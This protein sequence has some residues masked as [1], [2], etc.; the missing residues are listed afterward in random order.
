MAIGQGTLNTRNYNSNSKSSNQIEAWK[1]HWQR[2]R[3]FIV[4][5][6]LNNPSRRLFFLL[7]IAA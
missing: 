1:R 5:L 4:C 3:A 2:M 7:T 6:S